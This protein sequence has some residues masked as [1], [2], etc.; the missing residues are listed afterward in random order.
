MGGVRESATRREGYVSPEALTASATTRERARARVISLA[1]ASHELCPRLEEYLITA[2]LYGSRPAALHCRR[3]RVLHERAPRTH[4]G[5]P[6]AASRTPR[7]LPVAPSRVDSLRV[8]NLGVAADDGERSLG[9]GDRGARLVQAARPR[10]QGRGSTHDLLAVRQEVQGR[11]VEEQDERCAANP[12]SARDIPPP[13]R[14][15]AKFALALTRP[16]DRFPQVEAR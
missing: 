1:V 8:P 5:A 11:V 12:S 14:R 16:P 3:A 4:I 6:V 7:D 9:P 13:P 15:G 10:G 2:T